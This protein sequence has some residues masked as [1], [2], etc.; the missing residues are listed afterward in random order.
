MAF[1][2]SAVWREMDMEDEQNVPLL[3]KQ[4]TRRR[5][6]S[7][8]IG[9]VSEDL[10]S[11]S[12]L[13]GSSS[14]SSTSRESSFELP[15]RERKVQLALPG[16]LDFIQNCKERQLLPSMSASIA[17]APGDGVTKSPMTTSS[18]TTVFITIDETGEKIAK[19][20]QMVDAAFIVGANELELC[21]L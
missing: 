19:L 14:S 10:G 11:R 12:S 7:I 18:K 5:P 13:A 21:M 15:R 8:D 4:P 16:L 3:S 9:Y 1:H 6:Q 17:T 2:A 20:S